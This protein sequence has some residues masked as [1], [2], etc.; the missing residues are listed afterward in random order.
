MYPKVYFLKSKSVFLKIQKCIS[1]NLKVYFSK[2]KKYIFQNLKMYFSESKSI[3][4]YLKGYSSKSKSIFLNI[5][6]CI[7][8][9]LQSGKSY[10]DSHLRRITKRERVFLQRSGAVTPPLC[11][12]CGQP[13]PLHIIPSCSRLPFLSNTRHFSIVKYLSIE[14]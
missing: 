7:S 4:Q 2:S 12:R 6:K 9:D 8:E 10:R 13:Q 14:V 1:Q 3:S 5:Q 11:R